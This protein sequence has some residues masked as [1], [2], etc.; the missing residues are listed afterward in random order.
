MTV[1]YTLTTTPARAPHIAATLDSLQANQ[2][3][4][5]IWL[6]VSQET[7]QV[8]EA[9]F[10]QIEARFPRVR[11]RV[12]DD[13]GPGT[14]LVP[15]VEWAWGQGQGD[16]IL[17]TVDDDV[18]YPADHAA[19]L[20]AAHREMGD[21]P[22]GISGFS[23]TAESV[24][25]EGGYGREVDIL[26]G[27]AGVVLRPRFFAVDLG[28]G[29][30]L[31]AFR[32]YY[33]QLVAIPA[34]RF[35]DDLIFGNWL[36]SR[37]LKLFVVES[38]NEPHLTRKGLLGVVHGYGKG[39]ES[40][41]HLAHGGTAKRYAECHRVL[42][43]ANMVALRRDKRIEALGQRFNLDP[44][45]LKGLAFA[46][47]GALVECGRML[48]AVQRPDGTRERVTLSLTTIPARFEKITRLLHHFS[49]MTN[50]DRVILNIPEKYERFPDAAVKL[51]ASWSA[52]PKLV[53]H[54]C[55]DDYG[56]GTKLLGALY[57]RDARGEPLVRTAMVMTVDDDTI[58]PVTAALELLAR[59]RKGASDGEASTQTCWGG[60][61]FVFS[62]YFAEGPRRYREA[63]GRIVDVIEGFG[64]V[65]Y[66]PK[67]FIGGEREAEFRAYF[68]RARAILLRDD[69]ILFSNWLAYLGVE[70]RTTLTPTL[71][72]PMM[73]QLD[74][75]FGKAH[76]ALHADLAENDHGANRRRLF[77][78]M[79]AEG[80]LH[81]E[82][83]ADV[84][85][86]EACP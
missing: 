76:G 75:G 10:P 35:S 81:L 70:R 63:D 48:E 73:R 34:L 24:K 42:G 28:K 3:V 6:N 8:L 54:R 85:L 80:L 67:W 56:P 58:Y 36:I 19:H 74:Y 64:G 66:D 27:Y 50:V 86:E 43:S 17:I 79:K 11:V 23:W 22:V 25:Q 78:R 40:A 30:S 84:P 18:C 14:K 52:I 61:G 53:V 68:E 82:R 55:K 1:Y 51:P 29:P 9:T 39:T 16:A 5:L 15:T 60:I 33:A 46:P 13:T 71:A 77:A 62:E 38:R 59:A 26:E 21:R 4:D 65:M 37:G 12:C 47:T 83:A 49:R 41:L 44:H 57:G 32:A 20:V 7:A 2:G 69:D 45:E 72:R 31:E